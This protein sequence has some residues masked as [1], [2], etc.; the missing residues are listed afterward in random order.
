MSK[1]CFDRIAGETM[2]GP[3]LVLVGV[4]G[5]IA[6]GGVWGETPELQF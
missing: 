4:Q 5:R 3:G 6:T 1:S 2:Q